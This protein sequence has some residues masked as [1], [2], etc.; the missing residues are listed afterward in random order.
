[1]IAFY[2]VVLS[3][4]K[5]DVDSNLRRGGVEEAGEFKQHGN[6]AGAVV[7][8]EDR[9]IPARL[10]FIVLRSWTCVPMRTQQNSCCGLWI[11]R[12]DHVREGE[13]FAS[14]SGVDKFLQ[15]DII[16]QPAK[17]FSEI[18]EAGFVGCRI[19]IARTEGGL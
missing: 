4:E 15:A 14:V 18:L 9:I 13:L 3:I 5:D 19:G 16:G 8:P 2:S 12:G 7:C 1:M 10:V 6:A 11:E 17:F